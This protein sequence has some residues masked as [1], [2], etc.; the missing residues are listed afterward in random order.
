MFKDDAEFQKENVKISADTIVKNLAYMGIL[1][2]DDE[3]YKKGIYIP[4]LIPWETPSEYWTAI[5]TK[6]LGMKKVKDTT[7]RT[8]FRCAKVLCEFIKKNREV[9]PSI[10]LPDIIVKFA[11]AFLHWQFQN[12]R[13]ESELLDKLKGDES[14]DKSSAY[15]TAV[16]NIFTDTETD[17][18]G[19]QIFRVLQHGAVSA[20]NVSKAKTHKYILE[21]ESFAGGA[22]GVASKM[23]INP[24]GP[25]IAVASLT[26][27]GVKSVA[28]II[29]LDDLFEGVWDE[30]KSIFENLSIFFK[31]GQRRFVETMNLIL[32]IHKYVE[33]IKILSQ[34]IQRVEDSIA[35]T[36]NLFTRKSADGSD[37]ETIDKSLVKTGYNDFA[38]LLL[39]GNFN[40][41]LTSSIAKIGTDG[42]INLIQYYRNMLMDILN[43]ESSLK[44]I[45][46]SK[47]E[48]RIK[49]N[50]VLTKILV[51]LRLNALF[52]DYILM[53][54]NT[55]GTA[56]QDLTP[57]TN[58]DALAYFSFVLGGS[59][60][61]GSETNEEEE[62][63]AEEQEEELTLQRKQRPLPQPPAQPQQRTL[64]REQRP[65]PPT[66]QQPQPS[67]STR[68]R[69]QSQTSTP[70]STPS[71]PQPQ[72]K[73]WVHP[74]QQTKLW[75][76]PLTLKDDSSQN[77]VFSKIEYNNSALKLITV[78]GPN[79]P[80]AGSIIYK[81][82]NTSLYK[83]KAGNT[84]GQNN[85]NKSIN[86]T[87]GLQNNGYYL[88]LG[89]PVCEPV[90][91]QH[92]FTNC[93]PTNK[94]GNT[95]D[96]RKL[97]TL[98][99]S[100]YSNDT[101]NDKYTYLMFDIPG[102]G[103]S[104][105]VTI[106]NLN[107][108]RLK[109]ITPA[110]VTPVKPASVTP[111]KPASVTPVTPASVTPVTPASVTPVTPAAPT[112]PAAS[113]VRP[114]PSQQPVKPP[115]PAP[116][117]TMN[118]TM[119]IYKIETNKVVSSANVTLSEIRSA[120][121]EKQKNILANAEI[122]SKIDSL[123]TWVDR[124]NIMEDDMASYNKYYSLFMI[125]VSKI[126]KNNE[127]E[128]II[129]KYRTT[130]KEINAI[131]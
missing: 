70:S 58:V 4:T 98:N 75:V 129:R 21:S 110:S 81:N 118:D 41:L 67:I 2:N 27:I 125:E 47:Q 87:S 22:T 78:T 65:L 119:I 90:A 63:E 97:S 89:A 53:N 34:N 13:A 11:A 122:N 79:H 19:M 25:A 66:P 105:Q 40:G 128:P 43:N 44:V 18:Y 32:G 91:A 10:S 84:I 55:I 107:R 1:S 80:K 72:T 115:A 57:Y 116:P 64:R 111:V 102:V 35:R 76:H 49:F 36:E 68:P 14:S 121:I 123:Y 126:K 77:I 124:N 23:G 88:V 45:Q 73:L 9:N 86:I 56:T 131:S 74:Q 12:D 82:G 5:T 61:T 59:S 96:G 69:P 95:S 85:Q 109:K 24:L 42:M 20:K 26:V 17:E 38:M 46:G 93:K 106:N 113:S 15:I 48:V 50:K 83:Y 114:A 16:K 108:S 100:F 103:A 130:N 94:L 3:S 60:D 120:H 54:G 37:V 127:I 99:V 6:P 62:E 101:N 104:L 28:N 30:N 117:A 8:I 92:I 71:S 51:F 52:T 29:S 7:E 31:K 112:M 39:N 33:S